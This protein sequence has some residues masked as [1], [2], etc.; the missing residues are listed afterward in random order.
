MG[1]IYKIT[2]LINNKVYIGKTSRSLETRWQEH[3]KNFYKL[4]DKMAIHMAMFKYGSEA[5]DLEKIE[6]C[7]ESNI[8]EREQYWIDY[9][10][11]YNNGYNSTLGGEG[12]VKVD[13]QEVLSLWKQGLN[14]QQI[15]N[16]MK[17]D[18][19]TASNI[20]KI[21]NITEKEIFRRG[22]GRPVLQ[23][24]LEGKFV[25]R[26]DSITDAVNNMGKNNI[27][28][29]K[30]CCN[31]TS[32]SAYNFLWKYED[33]NTSIEEIIYD[34]KKSGKGKTKKVLQYDLND[35]FIQKHNSCR[36]AARTI[37]A[38]Y[39]VGINS[40]CLGRQKTAYGYKWKYEDDN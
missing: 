23:Y 25:N 35:N 31:K 19:H 24:T 18:R 8:N 10:N 38:P 5:F 30:N 34:F 1:C 28:A 20:L 2:N 39:H 16:K 7:N 13:Y 14:L 11:S 29:I 12:S 21:Y 26:F 4:Q 33:D 37:N 22:I 36:E 6:N 27:G 32:K 40:C 17:I 9:Y 15:T 3:R